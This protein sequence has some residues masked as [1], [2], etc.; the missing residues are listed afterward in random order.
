MKGTILVTARSFRDV[1]GPHQEALR[2]AGYHLVFSPYNRP[3]QPDELRP[4]VRDAV[5]VILGVDAF[6]RE[7]FEQAPHLKV[8]SRF[9]VGV[10]NVDIRAAT[11]HRVVVTITPGANSVAV[12]ELTML[13]ILALSRHLLTHDRWVRSGEWKRTTGAELMGATLGIIG[14]GRIGQEVAARARAFGMRVVFTDPAPPPDHVVHRLEAVPLPLD[15]LLVTS[16]VVSLHLPL[17]PGTRHLIGA[18]ELALMKP[19]ALLINT[20]RGGL[21]DERALYEALKAGRLAG[22]AFDVFEEEPPGASP[23][24][25][26][27]NFIATPHV[28]SATVQTARRMGMMAAQNVLAVLE[29]RRPEG[30]VNPQIFTSCGES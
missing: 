6:T 22:A 25:E 30:V 17:T 23:L 2:Q 21:V 1:E 15:D 11:E 28:G 14:L 26:L 24:L 10:D 9:G 3:L 29:G 20:A 8:I 19:T 5:G 13:F 4:L 7:V 27:E 18:R 16:D 12:A